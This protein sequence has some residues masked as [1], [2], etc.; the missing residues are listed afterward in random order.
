MFP[1]VR[2]MIV[3]V[4]ASIM[5]ISCALGLFA[6]FRVSHDS[7]LRES[8]AGAPLQLGLSGAGTIMNT[9]TTFETRFQARPASRVARTG[10][11]HQAFDHTVVT[12]DAAAAAP[13]INAPQSPP[14]VASSPQAV[15]PQAA[16]DTAAEPATPATIG[17]TAA[18]DSALRSQRSPQAEP[19]AGK[20]GDST[21]AATAD[22]KPAETKAAE[23][24]PADTKPAEIKP[25]ETKPAETKPAETKPAETKPAETKPAETK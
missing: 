13:A 16:F 1:N 19:A 21:P 5:G 24:K 9:P 10:I 11:D 8:N 7:F 4:L 3:A 18:A 15:A 23:I 12:P 14:E 25:A 2:L 20:P 6:E 22:N 17:S